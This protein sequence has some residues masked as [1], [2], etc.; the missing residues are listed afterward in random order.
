MDEGSQCPICYSSYTN[1][2]GHRTVS[3]K[4]GHIFG[5][6][7]IDTWFGK[8]KTVLC[9][10]CS[11][12]SRKSDKRYIFA[13]KILAFEAEKEKQLMNELY[14]E[15]QKRIQKENEITQ[16]TSTI[17]YLNMEIDKLESLIKN[18]KEV[19]KYYKPKELV[20]QIRLNECGNI[21]EYEKMN[22]AIII[23]CKINDN[24][25]FRKYRVDDWATNEFVPL[26]IDRG[27]C[28]KDCVVSPYNDGMVL[29]AYG[30]IIK[31]I[32]CY[33][34]NE[35]VTYHCKYKVWSI[36]FDNKERNIIYCGDE[37]GFIYVFDL[38]C[39]TGSVGQLY[40]GSGPV[41]SIHKLDDILYCG[42]IEE[43]VEIEYK[44]DYKLVL[45]EK[46]RNTDVDDVIVYTHNLFITI[47][48][49]SFN[50]IAQ[51]MCITRVFGT[52]NMSITCYRTSNNEIIH[53]VDDKMLNKG[54]IQKKRVRD[55][56]NDGIL[57]ILNENQNQNELALIDIK[58]GRTI[59]Q[60]KIKEE[61]SDYCIN[62]D[63]IYILLKDRLLVYK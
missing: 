58:D 24:I 16:L 53:K 14:E 47:N 29:V 57:Y 11:R 60:I 44:K 28:I 10:T 42:T 39:L 30:K 32:N 62:S 3:L 15:T 43:V 31:L 38:Y 54:Y 12:P 2:G 21:I 51:N 41:H 9:P 46:T 40:V 13:T 17:N 50:S 26:F 55:K 22:N 37:C 7:C 6:Q 59:D 35:L 4:C 45:K 5:D 34:N 48:E 63:S 23:C 61:V 1:T 52:S 19:I 8:K 27:G 18:E 49:Q 20:K 56:I 25:G 33:N 36:C